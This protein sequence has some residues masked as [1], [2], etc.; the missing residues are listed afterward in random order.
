MEQLRNNT[1]ASTNGVG[2]E[3]PWRLT[4]NGLLKRFGHAVLGW[5]HVLRVEV[6]PAT[7]A[8]NAP[9]KITLGPE[10][11]RPYRVLIADCATPKRCA[12]SKP[13]VT[14]TLEQLL[15]GS[16]LWSV[17]GV[18]SRLI[19]VGLG[20]PA[21]LTAGARTDAT[22]DLPTGAGAFGGGRYWGPDCSGI[23]SSE[24]VGFGIQ[25]I[26][27]VPS[28]IDHCG[29]PVR[30]YL[31]VVVTKDVI[32]HAGK[33][34]ATSSRMDPFRREGMQILGLAAVPFSVE[35]G[36]PSSP[37]TASQIS[38]AGT[39]YDSSEKPLPNGMD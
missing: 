17:I 27:T 11:G 18:E 2:Y 9:T 12:R 4:I 21:H 8:A 14:L 25:V 29:G 23:L 7:I 13:N 30:G 39:W 28:G 36:A 20:S 32:S 34:M 1:A 16:R 38:A 35:P 22:V 24:R 3:T 37:Q 31:Y 19:H 5:R 33:Q 10:P 15:P 6:P 26:V